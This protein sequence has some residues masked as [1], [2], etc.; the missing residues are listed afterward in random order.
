MGENSWARSHGARE[1]AE[2][3]K[4]LVDPAAW[5][6]GDFSGSEAWIWRLS[7][8]ELAELDSAVDRI[9]R[10]G[11][12][13]QDVGRDDFPLPTLAAGLAEVRAE[14]LDGRGFALVRG[15]PV[16][17]MSRARVA[18]AFW[19]MGSH[20]GRAL[21]QNAAGHVLGHVTDLGGDYAKVRGYLTNAQMG[22]HTDQ[23][24]VLALAC[25]HGAKSGGD[26]RICSSVALYNEML[27]R[28]PELVRELGWKFYRSRSG[29][30]PAGETEPWYRQA[31]FN[32]HDG[33]FAARGVS[34]NLAKAQALPGVP[35]FT[36]AQVEAMDLFRA[37]AE[38]L[39]WAVR[40]EPGDVFF[41]NC[42]VTLHSRTAFED[43]PEPERR[44][45]LLRLWLGTGGARPLPPEFQRQ[46][47]GIP[48]KGRATV[49][50]LDA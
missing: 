7:A 24:D 46:A 22:F 26:H 25:L 23:C 16:A 8:L 38:E 37:L 33:Y 19:G 50:P 28:R 21:S 15:L 20:L 9:E 10:R 2:L 40:F 34:A 13:I 12:D 6:G 48:F 31:I 45:H 11:L 5:S 47:Q 14:L 30:I 32:F 27:R 29:E 4:P 35:P 36:P 1:P 42:H 39:A 17:R 43:W 44:R 18:A 3:G 41:L 49:A